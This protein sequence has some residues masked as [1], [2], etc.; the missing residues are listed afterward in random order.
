MNSGQYRGD[1]GV[2]VEQPALVQEQ[3]DGRGDALGGRAHDLGGVGRPRLRA[4]DAFGGRV[5]LGLGVDALV[6][7]DL[8]QAVGAGGGVEGDEA[9]EDEG[10]DHA[11]DP[12]LPR[13]ASGRRGGGCGGGG[14]DQFAVD[15]ELERR[16]QAAGAVHQVGADGDHGADGQHGDDG[17]ADA[18]EDVHADH[19]REDLGDGDVGGAADRVDEG[20]GGGRG[21]YGDERGDER[22]HGHR[23]AGAR[24]DQDQAAEEPVGHDDGDDAH[25][26]D[27]H[28]EGGEA[29]VGEEDALHEQDDG[30]AQDAGPGPDEDRG[31]RTAEEVSAGPGGDRE[32]QHLDGEDE[33]R[34]EA[35]ERCGPLVQLAAGSAQA[36]GDGAGGDDTGGGRYGG[37]DESVRYMHVGNDKALLQR[38]CKSAWVT[39]RRRTAA[40]DSAHTLDRTRMRRAPAGKE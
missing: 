9:G 22:G 39:E 33:G 8:L 17:L 15:A 11:A 19:G 4:V 25:D 1:G 35:G 20:E 34:D 6:G 40:R 14:V 23:A 29:S 12:Q 24:Q 13:G 5:V 31:E 3:G 30:Y 32:V 2:Q 21:R 37:V 18:D 38:A 36:D 10:G 26:R 7:G 28:A 27:V 16:G